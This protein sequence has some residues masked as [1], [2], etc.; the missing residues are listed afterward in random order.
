MLAIAFDR[1]SVASQV[2]AAC[3]A[4]LDQIR[5]ELTSDG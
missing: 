5:D 2:L 1:E 4:N 3:G